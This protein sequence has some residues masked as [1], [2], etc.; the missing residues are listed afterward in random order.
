MQRN[1]S[2]ASSSQSR[3]GSSVHAPNSL[4]QR[5][6]RELQT[7][8]LASSETGEADH[9]PRSRRPA[10]RR[11]PPSVAYRALSASIGRLVGALARSP[12]EDDVD[13]LVDRIRLVAEVGRAVVRA[14]VDDTRR[15]SASKLGER[16]SG[17][18]ARRAACGFDVG[19]ETLLPL[20]MLPRVPGFEV[21]V[22]S[23]RHAEDSQGAAST[24]GGMA[25]RRIVLCAHS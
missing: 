21:R 4:D 19:A 7:L 8:R 10:R 1:S 17:V 16:V 25:R 5:A 14:R 9:L 12:G 24:L 20:E 22:A 13:E 3:V 6:E 15:S 23:E 18:S 11:A 2:V